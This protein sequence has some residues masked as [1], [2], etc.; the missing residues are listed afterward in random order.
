MPQAYDEGRL[1]RAS[2]DEYATSDPGSLPG[3][4][5]HGGLPS[6]GSRDYGDPTLIAGRPRSSY[7]YVIVLLFAAGAD[8]GAFFQIIELVLA[9]DPVVLVYAVVF[10]FTATALALAH[11]S[12]A[13]SRDRVAGAA[14]VGKF[15]PVLCGITWLLLGMAAFYARITLLAAIN[16]NGSLS[17]SLAAPGVKS[18]SY[19]DQAAIVFLALYLA[20]GLVTWMGAYLSRN[21]LAEGY[22]MA[23]RAFNEAWH[24]AD[25]S[26]VRADSAEAVLS[27]MR[28]ELAA[29]EKTLEYEIQSRLALAEKLRLA[30]RRPEHNKEAADEVRLF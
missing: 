10:G 25:S 3:Q 23:S 4:H 26:S 20:T 24:Q 27:F 30:H 16:N 11:R 21:P 17:L 1:G 12:G 5:Y 14:W 6:W 28:T 2:S 18:T 9:Q 15:M 13:L 29:S 22:K 8:I 19:A 7:M